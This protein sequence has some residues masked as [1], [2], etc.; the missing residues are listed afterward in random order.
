MSTTALGKEETSIRKKF[1]AD[2][3]ASI[4][5]LGSIPDLGIEYYLMYFYKKFIVK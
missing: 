4:V 1:L 2:N 5:L 3:K